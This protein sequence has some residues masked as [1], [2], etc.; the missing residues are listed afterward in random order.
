MRIQEQRVK[1]LQDNQTSK[2]NDWKQ[3]ILQLDF[4]ALKFGLD[5]GTDFAREIGD[6]NY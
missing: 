5:F 4:K 2:I 6:N 3:K 1:E